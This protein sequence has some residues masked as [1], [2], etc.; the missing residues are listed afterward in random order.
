MRIRV[1][2]T[3]EASVAE[4]W[5]AIKTIE[6]HVDW[7]AD[8]ESI[9]FTTARTSGTGTSFICVTKVGPIR[10]RDV[11]TVTEWSPRKA[12]GI[13]HLGLVRG[14]GRFTLKAVR[15]R[16]AGST[17]ATSFVWKERLTFPLWMGGPVGAL[18]A[19]PVLRWIWKR[20]LTRLKRLIESGSL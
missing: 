16:G 10:L 5:D 20:N 4:V 2:V 15:R 18:C 12:M 14:K 8:A 1:R 7:M 3:I 9:E 6:S 19:K 17:P 13:E 11:M